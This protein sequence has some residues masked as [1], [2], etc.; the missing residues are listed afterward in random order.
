MFKTHYFAD[1]KG[2]W[3]NKEGPTSAEYLPREPGEVKTRQLEQDSTNQRRM[4]RD[5]QAIEKRR[6][7]D[8]GRNEKYIDEY[9]VLLD[10]EPKTD[11]E[12]VLS[13][14]SSGEYWLEGDDYDD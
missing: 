8:H 12:K 10:P 13:Q 14:M 11:T 3:Y 7:E 9:S 5:M 4:D 1:V 2:I 6:E